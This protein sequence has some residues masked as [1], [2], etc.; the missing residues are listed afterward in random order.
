MPLPDIKLDDRSFETLVSDARRR[1]P[2]YTPEW[3]DFNESDPG[4]TLVQLF[5]WLEEMILWRLNRVP[6]K[7]YIEFLRL[8][9][10]EL[11][12]PAP[13]NAEL[14]FT[15]S[16]TGS[17]R[18]GLLD[19]VV[20]IPEGTKVSTN[21][22]DV[23]G[24]VIFETD[25]TLYAVGATLTKLQS[26]DGSQFRLLDQSNEIDGKFFYPFGLT[27]PQR[28]AAFYLGFDR[29]F[30]PNPHP[31]VPRPYVL[32]IHAYTADLIEEGKGIGTDLVVPIPPVVAMW[33]YW[34]GDT[35][36]WQTLNPTDDTTASL[37]RT[38]TVSFE[39]PVGAVRTKVG[40]L[41]K[42]EDQP[43]F[44]FRYR[45]DEELGA[46]YETVPRLEDVLINTVKAKNVVTVTG[47]L[48]GASDGGP[49]QK[50][51]LANKPVLL[52]GFILEVDERTGFQLWTKVDNFANSTR[53]DPHY[54]LNST[55]GEIAFGDG[56]QGKIP[57]R[58]T[59]PSRPEEDL[60]NI[61]ASKYRWGG[62]VRGN[63]GTDKVTSL[64]SPVPY[65][66]SVTN[67]RPTSG[68][69]D[70][71]SVS[72][73]KNRAPQAIRTQSRAVTVDDFEF[74]AQ[75]TPGVRIRRA[76][77]LAQHNPNLEPIRPVGVAHPPTA[78]PIPGVVT[79][80]VVPDSL[81]AS[82]V[83]S[84]GTLAAVA[85]WLN[86]HRLITTELYVVAPKYRKVEIV[87]RVIA[88]RSANSGQVAQT[89]ND[90]LLAYFHPLTGGID[91]TG[92]EFGGKI[93][94]SDTYRTILE[95]P[96][97]ARLEVGAV[98]TYVDGLRIDPATEFLL[99]EDELVVSE[100]HQIFASYL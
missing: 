91:G 33:E 92:W 18:N 24:P 12:P 85:S 82:P 71:E 65:V 100:T 9:G 94:F 64:Q 53:T 3:T 75:R 8:I 35:A 14:T 67:L 96:G 52:D 43:L 72:E 81:S 95:T 44:W 57:A 86:S 79:V 42:P 45:I 15:L 10:M 30:P 78:V 16:V 68:G 93:Y 89:V 46:G 39:G 51:Q 49:N 20:P 98:T 4:I 58:L 61:R 69:Q 76:H 25:E 97:V 56:E 5:A 22:Q 77:A 80:I 38:G 37:T 32:T 48:L 83:P 90:R 34:A 1:I 60:A 28:T 66:D 73:A 29:I 84:Q 55:T 87:A 31:D 26:F 7:N 50:F 19:L 11:S 74:L 88:K 41:Q 59:E 36:K 27:K 70:E 62:G 40:L 99:A 6:E 23:D 2:G 17:P 63:V 21:E 13:A 47:E 54:T